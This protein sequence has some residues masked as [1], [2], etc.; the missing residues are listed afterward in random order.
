LLSKTT[1][2]PCAVEEAAIAMPL[3]EEG[4]VTQDCTNDVTSTLMYPFA[5]V[6]GT[7]TSTV[8]RVGAVLD[9]TVNSAQAPVTGKMSTPPALFTLFTYKSNVAFAT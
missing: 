7:V 5:C 2:V 1:K 8:P 6:T 4:V 9:V 3:F